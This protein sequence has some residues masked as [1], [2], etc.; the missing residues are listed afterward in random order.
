MRFNGVQ[1]CLRTQIIDDREGVV[2]DLMK[3]GLMNI[4]FSVINRNLCSQPQSDVY[5][6]DYAR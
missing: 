5:L 4:H 1:W 3:N 2:P 6:H